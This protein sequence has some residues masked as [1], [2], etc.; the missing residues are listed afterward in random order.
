M[1][2]PGRNKPCPCGSGKKYKKCCIN[3][4]QPTTAGGTLV[5]TDLDELSN[6]VPRLLKQGKFNQAEAVCQQLMEQYPEQIDALHRYAEVYEEKGEVRK[7]AEYYRKAAEFAERGDGFGE[8]PG[9]FF[10][11]KAL[12]LEGKKGNFSIIPCMVKITRDSQAGWWYT[13]P[14]HENSIHYSRQATYS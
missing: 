5:Y 2:T 6:Q 12:E 14:H 1:K 10:R 11:K 7:A 9:E 8:S 4:P 13:L 3:A